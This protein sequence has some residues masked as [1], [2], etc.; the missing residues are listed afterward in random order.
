[1]SKMERPSG[2]RGLGALGVL[3]SYG[4]ARVVPSAGVRRLVSALGSPDE[5]TSMAAYMALAKLGPRNAPRLLEEAKKGPHTASLVQLLGDLGD[6]SIIPQLEPFAGS[7]DP[8]VASAARESI[9][10]LR[11]ADPEGASPRSGFE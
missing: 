10:A 7:P 6:P 5:D 2:G 4:M 3:V 9:D 11:T 1:M 8:K